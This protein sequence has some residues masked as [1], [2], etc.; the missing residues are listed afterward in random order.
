MSCNYCCSGGPEPRRGFLA[1][2]V[3][4]LAGAVALLTPVGVGLASFLN[5]LRQ[6]GQGGGWLK[7]ASLA[8]LPDD[9]TPRKFPVITDRVDAWTRFVNEPVGAVFVRRLPGGKEVAAFQVICP[10]AGCTINF[11]ADGQKFFC[12]CHGASFDLAGARTDA[13]SPS[14]RDMDVL[15]AEVRDQTEVWVKFQNFATGAAKKIA[16]A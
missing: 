16:S 12:P 9:G 8:T 14:P 13:V 4:V 2:L 3:A 11:E 6:K 10:H 5:P 15:E 7:I 1:K